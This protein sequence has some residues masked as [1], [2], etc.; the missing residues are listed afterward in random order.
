M[1][2]M[3]ALLMS[4]FLLTGCGASGTAEAGGV[5][6]TDD[7]GRQITVDNPQRVAAL[8][9]SFAQIWQL[10][11]GEVIA[12]ADD[13]WDDLQL[14]L[15]ADTVNLGNTK[16]LSMEL[17]LSAEP[18][19]I[20]ASTN[21]RQNVEWKETLE[22]TKIPV[23]YFDVGDFD[24]YL[25]LL[26]ICTDITGRKDLYEVNGLTV[27]K[28]IEAVLA[29]SRRRLSEEEAPT[30]LCM[31]AS[32][33]NISAKNSKNNVLGEMLASL[34]CVNIADSEKSLLENLS[35]E[36]I[37]TADPDYIFIVQRGDD[38]DGMMEKIA[39]ELEGNP[40]WSQLS[41]VK[42]GRV[43]IM[44]KNLYNLKPNHRWGE[45]YERLEAIL[46][47]EKYENRHWGST[48]ALRGCSAAEYLPWLRE[49]DLEPTVQRTACRSPGN[50]RIYLLVFPP[51]QNG[52]LPAVR[53]GSCGVRCG[54][55]DC[56]A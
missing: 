6:F 17:L 21:T 47:N 53:R 37:L 29:Q 52:C 25:R 31:V 1:K 35:L 40:L 41:A 24:D 56:A 23:A 34:G 22:A 30:V 50:C 26:K 42:D 18:D 45:A 12:T 49:T 28:Q 16:S 19:F 44:E 15:P 5:T 13:A 3:I 2:R 36:Y 43:Y 4:L 27:Q 14:E 39:L 11:G 32:A 7:L 55:P 33:S 20:L 48:A 51:A 9:G 38:T 8:L 10:A 46:S 54:D